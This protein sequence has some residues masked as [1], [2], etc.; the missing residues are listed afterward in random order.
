MNKY[1]LLIKLVGTS[2]ISISNIINLKHTHS[3]NPQ[4]G[5]YDQ[6]ATTF[7][8]GMRHVFST[9]LQCMSQQVKRASH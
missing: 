8:Q 5:E 6:I 1:T 2:Q 9:D 3:K 4:L 7:E